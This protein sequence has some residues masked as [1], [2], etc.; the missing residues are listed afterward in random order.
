M[1]ASKTGSFLTDLNLKVNPVSDR[2]LFKLIDQL[3]TKQV[4]D[5]IKQHCPRREITTPEKDASSTDNVESNFKHL[6]VAEEKI[7]KINVKHYSDERLKVVLLNDVKSVRPYI[8]SCIVENITFNDENFKKF[9]QLQTKIHDNECGKR[10]FATIATHDFKKLGTNVLT[11]TAV[12]PKDLLIKPLGKGVAVTG[13][14]LYKKLQEE[15]ENLRKE[16]KRNVYTGIHKYLYLLEGK[17]LYP[18]IVA[19]EVVSFPPI[20]NSDVTKVS[21]ETGSVFL[22]VTSSTTQEKCKQVLDALL[23]EMLRLL[24]PELQVQ[25]VRVTDVD[26]NLKAVYPSRCD[27][28]YSTEDSIEVIRG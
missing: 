13:A 15:A 7:Y 14:Q 10:N 16:K 21:T 26:G 2:R 1:N 3:K 22:E 28:N 4:I 11:Y 25:Q 24:G 17:K 5:Y 8:L 20:T 6:K 27:L 18:C 19:N 23:K 12:P 9:I